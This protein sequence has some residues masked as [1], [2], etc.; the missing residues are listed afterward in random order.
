MRPETHRRKGRV[1]TEAEVEGMPLQ[2]KGMPRIASSY[3]GGMEWVLPQPAE[4]SH[5]ADM[6]ILGFWPLEL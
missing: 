5:P 4:G 6:F 2:A 1:K 3:K